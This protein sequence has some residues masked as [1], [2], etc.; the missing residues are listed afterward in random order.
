MNSSFRDE[1]C[2]M[3]CI[4]ASLKHSLNEMSMLFNPSILIFVIEAILADLFF[5]GWFYFHLFV[6]KNR[7]KWNVPGNSNGIDSI[8]NILIR[9]SH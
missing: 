9:Y 3:I 1:S 5:I 2:P 4:L 8:V 7:G 6:R